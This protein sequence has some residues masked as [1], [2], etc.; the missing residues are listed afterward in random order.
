MS[1]RLALLPSLVVLAATG[2]LLAGCATNKSVLLGDGTEGYRVTCSGMPYSTDWD[3]Q[4]R[5]SYVCK[6]RGGYT[7]V[8][9]ADPPY[10]HNESVWLHATHDIVIRC[11]DTPAPEQ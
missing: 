9:E 6:A 5:A 2:L 11:N 8:K 4:D 7:V 1:S 3:C 10:A